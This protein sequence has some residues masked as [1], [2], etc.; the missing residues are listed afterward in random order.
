M[1]ER[2]VDNLLNHRK[3]VIAE[4]EALKL[5]PDGKNVLLKRRQEILDEVPKIPVGKGKRWGKIIAW[6]IS[7]EGKGWELAAIQN[8]LEDMG[9]EQDS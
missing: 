3:E 4:L 8:A 1:S 6:R 9:W 2:Y 7:G 5:D